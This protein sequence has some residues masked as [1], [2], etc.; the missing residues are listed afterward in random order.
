M[1]VKELTKTIWLREGKK[2]K[3]SIAD[4]REVVAILS[5]LI[6]EVGGSEVMQTLI[7]NGIARARKKKSKK[8]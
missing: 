8:K 1:T 2:S 5:D 3:V 4:C 6:I 7:K